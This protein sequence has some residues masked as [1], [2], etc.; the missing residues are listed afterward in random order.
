MPAIL[1]E[2]YPTKLELP[3][4]WSKDNFE[5]LTSQWIEK[6]KLS[7]IYKVELGIHFFEED[8]EEE[9]KLEQENKSSTRS[10]A[11]EKKK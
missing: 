3:Q 6:S 1:A 7:V 9:K 2:D 5:Y 10:K 11:N 8:K 4:N